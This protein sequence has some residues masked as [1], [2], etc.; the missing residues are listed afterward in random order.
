MNNRPIGIFD[1][2]VGGITVLSEIEKILPYEDIVYFGDTARVPY[3]NKSQSTIR[4]F[5]VEN[6]LF[7]LDKKVKMVIVACNTASSLAM[8]YLKKTFNVYITGVI[9]PGVQKALIVSRSSVIGV[10]G[11]RSTIASASYEKEI[12]KYNPGALVYS[13]SCPL[14]VPLV[15]E[16]LLTG[17]ITQEVIEMYLQDFKRKRVDSLIL[18]CTHYPLLKQEISRYL[19]D[20]F[21]VDS[22]KEVALHTKQFLTKNNFLNK[23]KRKG[24][25]DFY[26]TD[27][28][29]Q[30]IKL[31]KLFLKRTIARPEVIN[32]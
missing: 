29:T 28:P 5:S 16:G 20:T 13:K 3:G 15:E 30:F 7:L 8:D 4:K 17:K 1:S 19:Q 25:K 21:I 12:A 2:G 6:I 23:K 9:E 24:K 31:A 10:V 11:T 32:V 22:A 14:F 27:E 18:G 26:V